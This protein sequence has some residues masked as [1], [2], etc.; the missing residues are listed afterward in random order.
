M[1]WIRKLE[2]KFNRYAIPQLMNY[3]IAGQV[4]VFM[5]MFFIDASFVNNIVL[6]RAYVLQG[7]VWRLLTFV[8]VPTNT[9]ILWFAISAYFYYFIG[10]ALESTWGSFRLNLYFFIGVLGAMVS[11]MLFGYAS[12]S[13][14]LTS[15]FLAYAM[16]YP[17]REVY[18]L[19]IPVKVKWLGWLA[20]AQWAISFL[21]TGLAGK[22]SL[23]LTMAGFIAFFG[24]D[25]WD[26]IRAK[27]R[28]EQWKR[29]NRNNWR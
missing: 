2:R 25:F 6:W 7:Q 23:V 11:G 28:R 3:V 1:D 4:F 17:E 26:S 16:L 14:L 12:N 22:A 20:G 5:M 13:A 21:Q 27:I 8:F 9:N 29:K 24:R 18:L 15:L 19:F 10:N